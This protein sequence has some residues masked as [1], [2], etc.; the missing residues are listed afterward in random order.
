MAQYESSKELVALLRRTLLERG[1]LKATEGN[2]SV[3]VPGRAALA[4]TPSSLDYS[5]MEAADV[6][7]LDYR[8]SVLSGGK[9]AS[10]EAGMHAAVYQQRPDVNVIIH[11]HQPYASAL[12]LIRKPI[13]ALF[14]E[15]ARFL[16]RSVRDHRLR[17]VRHVVPR[18]G[19]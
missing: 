17:A 7:V 4:I 13:P 16:G 5:L 10:I 3:R 18:D 19:A 9:K 8:L 2:V 14:D 15:Q 12:A 6:C 11:T 1:Y